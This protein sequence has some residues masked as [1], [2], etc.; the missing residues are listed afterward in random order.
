MAGF[1]SVCYTCFVIQCCNIVIYSSDEIHMN[2]TQILKVILPY[3]LYYKSKSQS[4]DSGS[5][6]EHGELLLLQLQDFCGPL[7][8]ERETSSTKVG[9]YAS[10]DWPS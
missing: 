2:K 3:M 1:Q 4:Y 8:V 7:A 6:T 9:Q 10:T 5:S